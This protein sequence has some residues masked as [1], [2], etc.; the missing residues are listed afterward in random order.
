MLITSASWAA[1]SCHISLMS[2]EVSLFPS[3]LLRTCPSYR[4]NLGTSGPVPCWRI[5]H[6]KILSLKLQTIY[7]LTEKVM[8]NNIS[9][10]SVLLLSKSGRLRDNKHIVTL[11]R[12][13]ITCNW[14]KLTLH[15][16]KRPNNRM[17]LLAKKNMAWTSRSRQM[18][19]WYKVFFNYIP[20]PWST[21]HQCSLRPVW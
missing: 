5:E 7:T 2:S 8:S 15:K 16:L 1:F 20:V 13:N 10:T 19:A 9:T 17:I 12:L 3:R 14:Q 6:L 21:R 18:C 4:K 11:V